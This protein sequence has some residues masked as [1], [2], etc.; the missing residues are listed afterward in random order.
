MDHVV[1]QL[2]AIQETPDSTPG[3]GR[4]PGEEN[5]Q[6]F[7]YSFLEYYMDRLTEYNPRGHKDSDTTEWLMLSFSGSFLRRVFVFFFFFF[8]FYKNLCTVPH[9]ACVNLHSEWQCKSVPFRPLPLQHFTCHLRIFYNGPSDWSEMIAHCSFDL[10]F[11][12]DERCWASFHVSHEKI[13]FVSHLYVSFEKRPFRPLAYCFLKNW[14]FF[15]WY[16]VV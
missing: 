4:A 8:F 9:S 7:Q 3:L 16:W 15:S 5:G 1:K 11:F 2:S 12:N 13:F 6:P 10:H 14:V